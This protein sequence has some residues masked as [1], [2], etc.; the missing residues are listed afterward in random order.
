MIEGGCLCGKVRYAVDGSIGQVTHCHCSMCRRIHGAAFGT[1]GAV[2]YDDFRW[3][4]GESLVK[5]YRS[6]DV[7]ERTFCGECGSTL[8]AHFAV[9]PDEVYLALGTVDGDPGCRPDAHIFVGSKA[10]WYEITDSVPQYETW[11]DRYS[12]A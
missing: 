1:Y 11:T 9:E 5:T 10:P 7:M 6:S 3:L 12:G 2:S 4:S 8:Q